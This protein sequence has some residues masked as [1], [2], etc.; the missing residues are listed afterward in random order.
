MSKQASQMQ[1]KVMSLL[2]RGKEIF[3][4]LNTGYIDDHV[5]CIREYIANIFFYIKNG[6]TIMIDAGYSYPRLKEKMGW[7]SIDPADIK[8]IL[9]THQDT[10]HVGAVET[11]SDGLFRYATLYIGETENRYLT[12]ETPR[13][14]YKFSRLPRVKI[15]NEKVLLKDGEVFYIDDIKIESILVP[16]HTWGHMVFLIDDSYLFTGD[17]VW[18]G[19]DGGYSFINVLAEDN[20]LAKRSLVELERK[21]RARNLSPLIVTGHT[22]CTDSLDFAFAHKDKVCNAWVKQK[23][24]DPAAPYDGYDESDDKA[25]NVRKP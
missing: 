12:G 7:L 18:L 16:G 19:A 1:E 23:P 14:V 3:K 21:L 24:H 2:Y 20:K 13:K 6:T 22:G 15:D 17:T 11:D 10:D 5:G 25:E 4:P 9:I 8:H